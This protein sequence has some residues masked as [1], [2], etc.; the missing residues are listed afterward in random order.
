MIHLHRLVV[1]GAVAA[2]AAV[3]D[4]A[5][6]FGDAALVGAADAA[7]VG[8]DAVPSSSLPSSHCGNQNQPSAARHCCCCCYCYLRTRDRNRGFLPPSSSRWPPRREERL[9]RP[10]DNYNTDPAARGKT[11]RPTIVVVA[12]H[13]YRYHC[14][15]CPPLLLPTNCN[16]GAPPPLM[17][18]WKLH[19]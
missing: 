16:T 4:A 11:H 7:R 17:D 8:V 1:V 14:R 18:L 15:H 10:Y 3:A 5:A 19:Y 13:W 6:L 12:W 9:R 2:A